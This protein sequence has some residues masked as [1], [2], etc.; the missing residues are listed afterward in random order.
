[1]GAAMALIN[2]DAKARVIEAVKSIEKME[3]A[4]EP[5]FQDYFVAAMTFPTATEASVQAKRGRRRK[6]RASE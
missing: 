4:V 5:K 6:R 2:V 1:M 3:T